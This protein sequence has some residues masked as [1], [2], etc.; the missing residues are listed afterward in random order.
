[1][2]EVMNSL[3]EI[4]PLCAADYEVVA[5]WL[6]NP[7][8]NRWLA[9][10]WQGRVFDA[11]HVAIHIANPSNRMYLSR[12]GGRPVGL[13]ALS[14]FDRREKTA[15]LWYMVDR[16]FSGRGVATAAVTEVLKL[17]FG[18]LGLF[19]LNAWVSEGNDVSRH[20]LIRLGFHEVGRMRLAS[21][22]D[23]VRVDRF[24]YD[25]LADDFRHSMDL[26]ESESNE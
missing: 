3:V 4:E 16:E 1:M 22:L 6:S 21:I 12:C 17:A 13:V 10:A 26:L 5:G 24:V 15:N 8:V 25:L 14:G 11:R 23:E 9:T 19:S 20:L 7:D 18:D 2:V